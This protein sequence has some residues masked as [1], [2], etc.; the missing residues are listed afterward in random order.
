VW[1]RCH[2]KFHRMPERITTGGLL[3]AAYY[4]LIPFIRARA[5]EGSGIAR[6]P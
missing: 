3:K 2:R 1:C 6:S 5:P 4:P